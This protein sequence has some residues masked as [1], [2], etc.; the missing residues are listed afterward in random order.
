MNELEGHTS[1]KGLALLVVVEEQSELIFRG[2]FRLGIV[3]EQT[4][5]RET[6]PA[7]RG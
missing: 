6:V 7:P 5:V 4:L 1:T 2:G 3:R